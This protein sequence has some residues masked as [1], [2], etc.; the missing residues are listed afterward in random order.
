MV[1][2][3]F[4]LNVAKQQLDELHHRLSQTR[5][6]DSTVSSEDW[7]RGVPLSY[8]KKLADH[9]QHKFDW[10]K[11]E[12]WLNQYDQFIATVDGQPIHFFHAK[13]TNPAAM[14]LIRW[15]APASSFGSDRWRMNT[16]QLSVQSLVSNGAFSRVRMPAISS[17]CLCSSRMNNSRDTTGSTGP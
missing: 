16:K 9:W 12:A 7:S 17:A 6:P 4:K 2:K 1:I 10:R 3:P 15:N 13:S 11:Q 8:L 14:P 5:W